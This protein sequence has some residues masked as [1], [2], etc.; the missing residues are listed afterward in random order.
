MKYQ[1]FLICLTALITVNTPNFSQS[2]TKNVPVNANANE[3]YV[4]YLHGAIIQEKGINAVSEQYGKY[5]YTN[6]LF[7]LQKQGFNVISEARK[8]D[9]EVSDYAEKLAGQ[10]GQLLDAGVPPERIT[11]IGA[12]LGAF[13]TLEA[14]KILANPGVKYALLGLCGEYAINLF[15]PS[16]AS[17]HGKFFSVF[18]RSDSK[19]SC[20]PIFTGLPKDSSFSELE[21]NMGNEHGFLYKPYDEWV[22]P[23]ADFARK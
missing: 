8:K 11:V 13:M 15:K 12:S 14:A 16:A 5:E 18:E 2:I 10:V 21:L 7:A 23:V 22:A 3:R 1:L 19:G 20:A 17:L 6:I 9:T 4:F